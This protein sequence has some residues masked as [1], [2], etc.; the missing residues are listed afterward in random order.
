M[1]KTAR[2][3]RVLIGSLLITCFSFQRISLTQAPVGSR[4]II[5][6]LGREQA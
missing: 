1:I 6:G 2:N 5:L 3:A 4:R